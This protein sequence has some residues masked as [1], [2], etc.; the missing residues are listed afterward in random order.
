MQELEGRELIR[1][2]NVRYSPGRWPVL[3]LSHGFGSD[4]SVWR[5]VV[6][7]LKRNAQSNDCGVLTYDLA[8]SGKVG[9]DYYTKYSDRYQTIYGYVDDVVSVLQ[10]YNISQCIFVGHGI[11]ARSSLSAPPLGKK[12]I[13]ILFLEV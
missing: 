5:K 7:N 13:Y 10:F 11:S 3:V 6:S 4:Q 1:T 8:F 2:L 12:A 9:G